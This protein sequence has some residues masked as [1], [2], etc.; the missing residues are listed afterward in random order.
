MFWITQPVKDENFLRF[1]SVSFPQLT[2]YP[3]ID[4]TQVRTSEDASSESHSTF[5]VRWS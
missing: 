1:A 3:N 2:D 4:T 5:T